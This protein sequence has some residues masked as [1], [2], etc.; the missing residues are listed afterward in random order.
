MIKICRKVI[1]CLLIAALF[2][3]GTMSVYASELTG[4]E[5]VG[6]DSLDQTSESGS[7]SEN[8][9]E[10]EN[11]ESDIESDTSE[12]FTEESEETE[13]IQD[14]TDETETIETEKTTA[15]AI[16]T[17]SMKAEDIF[18]DVPK[19]TDNGDIKSLNPG[20]TLTVS[21]K[22]KDSSDKTNV[23]WMIVDQSGKT[24][25]VL[26]KKKD[27]LITGEASGYYIRLQ[28]DV[29]EGTNQG[30]QYKTILKSKVGDKY[31]RMTELTGI[32][33]P[34]KNGVNIY[35]AGDSTVRD[36]SDTGLYSDGQTMSKGSWGEFLGHFFDRRS[37]RVN[38]YANSLRSTRYFINEGGLDKIA[39]T[40]KKGDYLFIQ[41]SHND[42]KA[43]EE[44]IKVPLG[45]PDSNGIYPTTPGVLTETP[46][47]LKEQY[48]PLYYSASCGGT[49]KWYLS[50]YVETALDAGATPVLVT[51]I[52]RMRFDS[53]GKIIPNHDWSKSSK[54]ENAYV[55]AIQQVYNEYKAKGEK[56]YLIDLY[57]TTVKLYETAYSYKGNASLVNEIFNTGDTVHTNKLG[58]FLLA[59]DMVNQIRNSNMSLAK[60]VKKPA[61][62][63]VKDYK[64]NTS[65]K[66]DNNGIFT[67]YQ[68]NGAVAQSAKDSY[69]TRVGQY[70]L[71]IESSKSTLS[72]KNVKV[73]SADKGLY[74]TWQGCSNADGY[75]VY[76]RIKQSDGW[77]SWKV[78]QTVEPGY[79][80]KWKDT[81]ISESATYQYTVRAYNDS[82]KSAYTTDNIAGGA[83]V[84]KPEVSLSNTVKGV[85]VSWNKIKN[86]GG[87]YIYR[88]EKATDSWKKIKEISDGSTIKWTDTS[89][90]A[91]K[92]YY[93]TVVA[94]RGDNKSAYTEQ[95]SIIRM[96]APSVTAKNAEK[97]I[98]V[99]WNKV[100]GASGYY[101]YKSQYNGKEWSKWTRVTTIDDNSK[102]N[103]TDTSVSE[104]KTYRYTVKGYNGS[105]VSS[106]V[107]GKSIYRLSQPDFKLSSTS[108]GVKVQWS[109]NKYATGY[110]V[111]RKNS[112]GK[113][114]RVA[115][116]EDGN[117]VTWTDTNVKKNKTYTYTV[118][119]VR[120]NS[121]SSAHSG[122]SIKYQK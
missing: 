88:R 53:S 47:D 64:G 19:I 105:S 39:S 54:H 12:P 66:V 115:E 7:E 101:V 75:Y 44:E 15:S 63:N 16:E 69:W 31:D 28:I 23:Q 80:D 2:L 57:S 107:A 99:S 71:D 104:G 72:V 91:G 103:Y 74:I 45:T 120:K 1:G 89:A 110:Y 111:Y 83:Y 37:V 94:Y 20:H 79:L 50:Q 112:E 41:F 68:H 76:R 86:A 55:K 3:S 17:E 21:Y 51:P 62:L 70:L 5:E 85:Y 98:K 114:N 77:S 117:T 24:I 106:Y 100:S 87:Y 35:L 22:V 84:A 52:S 25:K 58:G 49:F 65:V 102:L 26:S 90:K 97:G 121:T 4:S 67:A 43:S 6:Y 9:D 10:T 78:V 118:K 82:G 18:S 56:I 116:I 81:S 96:E 29:T 34:L 8:A 48:G 93:Y 60:K 109:K 30:Y 27:C 122:K 46:A 73:R 38:N 36:Y 13:T 108:K 119:T 92:R 32:L 33:T 11:F 61:G 113:W 59:A 95:C 40:I 42:E 14:S